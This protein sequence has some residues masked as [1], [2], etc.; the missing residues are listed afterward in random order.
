MSG[1][2]GG[3]GNGG[4]GGPPGGGDPGMSYSA[5]TGRQ[6]REGAASSQTYSAP[7]RGGPPGGG[8]P[9]MT[10]TAPAPTPDRNTY[11]EWATVI[12]TPE[13]IPTVTSE[14]VS[15]EPVYADRI[16]RISTGEEPGYRAQDSQPFGLSKEEAYRQGKITVDQ[17]DADPVL[18]APEERDLTRDLTFAEHWNLAPDALKYSPTLRLLWATGANLGEWSKRQGA[19]VW[20]WG[21]GESNISPA[22]D[23]GDGQGATGAVSAAQSNYI[24][25]GQT[26]PSNSVAA[27][28]YQ[29]LG[30]GSA[31]GNSGAFN[32]ASEYAAAQQKVKQTLGTPSAV[33]MLAVNDS[34]FFDFLQ[35]HNLTK[36]IL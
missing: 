21:T 18:T 27:N 3:N 20:D 12:D 24:T 36:G 5:P 31:S 7:D 4:G 26:S 33:G 14:N 16:Q 2:G 10:Y 11:D 28:W 23:R 32:L 34:P 22:P 8:D 1:G 15:K 35:K 25:S 30:T 19:N 17:R 29:S 6:D 13:V 9:G